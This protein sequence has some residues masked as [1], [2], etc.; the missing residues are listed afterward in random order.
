[1]EDEKKKLTEFIKEQALKPVL[2]LNTHC[3]VDHIF[4][5]Q[6]IKN[7]YNIE[8]WAHT[9]DK[10]ILE[11]AGSF[12]A[13]YGFNVETPPSIDKPINDGDTIQF[14]NSTL[15]AIHVPGHSPGSIVFYNEAQNFMIVGD[16][17]FRGSIGRSDLPGGDHETLINGIRN[18]LFSKP[19]NTI[20]YPGHGPETSIEYEKEYNPFFN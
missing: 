4:G 3:H 8:Y 2:L 12:G 17:L 1:T 7:T 19:E 5:N 15:L 14:G 20:V 11:N 18:K 9:G 10:P 16:V 6:F 13:V